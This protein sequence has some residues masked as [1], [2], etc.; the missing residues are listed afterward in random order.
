[1]TPAELLSSTGATAHRWGNTACRTYIKSYQG[2]KD[3]LDACGRAVSSPLH[4][5][6]RAYGAQLDLMAAKPTDDKARQWHELQP[7]ANSAQTYPDRHHLEAYHVN[8]LTWHWE[9]LH[10]VDSPLFDNSPD[11]ERRVET[12][13]SVTG[14]IRFMHAVQKAC[15]Y[16]DGGPALSWPSVYAYMQ[17]YHRAFLV[18]RELCLFDQWFPQLQAKQLEL[19]HKGAAPHLHDDLQRQLISAARGNLNTSWLDELRGTMSRHHAQHPHAPSRNNPNPAPSIPKAC[20]Y[21]LGDHKTSQHPAEE[22]ITQPCPKCRH[23]HALVGKLATP[24]PAG[25]TA[26]Q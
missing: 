15:E 4:Y 14:R 9:L 1:M 26:D 23:P 21:C 16:G 18:S 17:R 20:A 25:P 10:V 24:C 3:H 11:G 6:N 12:I 13:L 2:S 5:A 22:P 8:M 19:L 7:P